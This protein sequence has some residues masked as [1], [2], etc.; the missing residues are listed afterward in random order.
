MYNL[1]ASIFELSDIEPY[2]KAG[3]H[4][5][6]MGTSFFS[7]RPCGVFSHDDIKTA[8]KMTQ[9]L[10]MNL[11]MSMNRMFTEEEL[12]DLREEL[13]FYKDM[14]VDGIY[15]GDE[16]VLYQAKKLKMEHLLIYNP[17]TLITNS[18]DALYYLDEGIS[19]VSLSKEITLIDMLAIGSALPPNKSEV[20]I[21]GRLNMM[22]SK[23]QLLQSY[24][25]HL[26][27]DVTLKD[28]HTLY[29]VENNRDER[30]P[31]LE[32]NLGTHVFTGFTLISFCEVKQLIA[33]GI[34]NFRIDGIFHD[35]TYICEALSLY[36]SILEQCGDAEKISD[37]YIKK[38]HD[39]HCSSGFYYQ[40][41]SLV[42][43]AQ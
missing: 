41:T 38:Y 22:H 19:M 4:S 14:K 7:A 11:Y 26:N 23:R 1:I 29:L 16:G 12:N 37:D 32:D 28:K 2:K 8:R 17:D 40:K 42:K 30:L 34:T 6:I 36:Q 15:Y 39:D 10:H 24:M 25:K 18:R 27:S 9:N 3:A 5:I 20:L 35:R 31:V 43:E 21:H 33:H 13:C